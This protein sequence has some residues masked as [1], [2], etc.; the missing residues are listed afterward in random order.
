MLTTTALTQ[1]D[2]KPC[3]EFEGL[4]VRLLRGDDSS[5]LTSSPY[6]LRIINDKVDIHG[7]LP[8]NIR[9]KWQGIYIRLSKISDLS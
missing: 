6:M 8:H 7:I 1:N 5:R 4:G 3:D 9:P 2:H